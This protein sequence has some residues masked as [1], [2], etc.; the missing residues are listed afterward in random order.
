MSEAVLRP[1]RLEDVDR[2]LELEVTLFGLGAW[3]RGMYEN[4]LS[5]PGRTYVAVEED[6]VLVGYAGANLGE[7]SH[8]M[9]IGVAPQARRRGYASRML[10]ELMA[11]ARRHGATSMLLEVRADDDGPQGLYRR[12]GFEQIGVRP[13]Y[14]QLEGADAVVMRAPLAAPPGLPGDEPPGRNPPRPPT[15]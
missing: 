2:V 3:T 5:T 10:S 11:T 7:E 12:F 15:A 14:Y 1:L 8:V 13:G 4:E 6:G 9:T